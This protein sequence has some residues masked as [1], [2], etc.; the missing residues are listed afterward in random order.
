MR[1]ISR[2]GVVITAVLGLLGATSASAEDFYKGKNI[3]F[4][5]GFAAGGG[6][7]AYA[8]TIARYISRHIPGNPSTVVEN[9]DGAGSVIAANY[10]YARAEK[11]GLTVGIWNSQNIFNHMMGDPSIR[12]DGRKFGWIGSPSIDSVAC[13]IM[14]FAGPKTFAE[15]VSSKKSL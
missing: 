4:I 7:D 6:Y 5:V 12:F 9:M 14:G 11:N 2:L 8:R 1:I 3:R 15:I 13:A 10:L